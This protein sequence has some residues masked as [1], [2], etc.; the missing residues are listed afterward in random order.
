MN[1]IF[2]QTGGAPDNGA[3]NAE[4]FQ[5]QT[6]NPQ[7]GGIDTQR[8]GGNIQETGDSDVLS[9]TDESIQVPV[10]PADTR[11]SG[12]S[13]AGGINWVVVIVATIVLVVVFDALLRRRDKRAYAT[14]SGVVSEEAT[15]TESPKKK[16]PKSTQKDG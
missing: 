12:A 10:N 16:H 3:S 7:P 1:S 11:D 9:R 6:R 4:D 2:A 8:S 5:P 15:A 14:D 13:P